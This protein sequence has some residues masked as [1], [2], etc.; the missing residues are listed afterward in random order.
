[1]DDTTSIVLVVE[2]TYVSHATVIND[3]CILQGLKPSVI[4]YANNQPT[5]LQLWD[6]NFCFISLS[7]T[8]EYLEDNAK[9]FTCS[10]F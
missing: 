4:S 1:M 2:P 3:V 6:S 8:N 9:K 7:R 10:L 5:D